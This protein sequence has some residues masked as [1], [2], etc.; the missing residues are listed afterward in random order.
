MKIKVKHLKEKMELEVADDGTVGVLKELVAA[1]TNIP[2]ENQRLV[3]QG[4]QL[5]DNAAALAAVGV[6]E[7]SVLMVTGSTAEEAF[8]AAIK[9]LLTQAALREEET[10]KEA[11]AFC[12]L[13]QHAKVL[14]AGPPEN[15]E[16]VGDATIG[17]I[18]LPTESGTGV[19]YLRDLID[20]RK[21]RIRMRLV[22]LENTLVIASES[23]QQKV[24]LSNVERVTSEPITTDG[25]KH[26]GYC[27]VTLH[28]GQQKMHLYWFPVQYLENMKQYFLSFK[29]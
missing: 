2:V 24:P 25:G 13:P 22:I 6:K 28:M 19:P 12:E 10:K 4:K 9:P 7:K 3:L 18:P 15:P 5:G 23:G 17:G 11:A 26:K 16:V 20:A 29:F 1:R 8:E 27:V 21:A 14:A